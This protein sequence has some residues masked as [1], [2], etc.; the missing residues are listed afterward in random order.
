MS[1][2]AGRTH[3]ACAELASGHVAVGVR[4]SRKIVKVAVLVPSFPVAKAAWLSLL[5]FLI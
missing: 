2:M 3:C 5:F 1:A 4:R